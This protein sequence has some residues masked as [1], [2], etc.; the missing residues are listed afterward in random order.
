MIALTS[1]RWWTAYSEGT[2]S[3]VMYTL[4]QPYVMKLRLAK[5]RENNTPSLQLSSHPLLAARCV[6]EEAILDTAAPANATGR[7]VQT[8]CLSEVLLAL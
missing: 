7:T 1:I 6:S 2:L 8:Y 3:H 5:G 4:R